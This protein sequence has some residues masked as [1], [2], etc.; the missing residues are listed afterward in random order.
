MI[1]SL[2][3]LLIIFAAVI[4]STALISILAYLLHRIRQI[5]ARTAGQA[6]SHQLADQVHVMREELL[7]FQEEMSALSERLDFTER[8]L[9]RGDEA[10]GSDR[11]E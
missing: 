8:L 6:G 2:T 7:T 10:A 11:S 3:A 1:S 4:G 9:M 5:E